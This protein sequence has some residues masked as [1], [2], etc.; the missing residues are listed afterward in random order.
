[1]TATAQRPGPARSAV[2]GGTLEV[3]AEARVADLVGWSA[4]RRLRWEASGVLAHD[5]W[6]WVVFDDTT[7]LARIDPA[8]D[9]RRPGSL[10]LR[11]G[12]S[13]GYEDLAADPLTGALFLLVESAPTPAGG[14]TAR[15]TELDAGLRPVA[16]RPLQL[17]LA[18][19]NK[20]LEGLTCVR[21]DGERFLLGLAED[22]GRVHVFAEHREAWV[23][24]ATIVL[25][26]G[27]PLADFSGLAHRDGR[28]AVVSQESSAL[29]VGRLE[30]DRWA[31]RDAGR[32]HGFPR[33]RRG[34]VVY[35]TVE[36]VSWLSDTDLVVV[37]DR[38]KRRQP[39][40][41]RAKDRS[42][43]VVRLPAG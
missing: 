36:G 7:E 32:V 14:L 11:P 35:G 21:R 3:L 23:L 33:D 17:P 42:V 25:P 37:S 27:L 39:R 15:V 24:R 5:G 4:G 43:H 9:P 18:R 16:D 40:R 22:T 26:E 30:P 8:M 10:L 38:C 29:W 1:M 34:R 13:P 20:G 12:R 19:A 41:M 28:L 2:A 6:F 31:V